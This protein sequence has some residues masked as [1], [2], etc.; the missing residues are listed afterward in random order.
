MIWLFVCF[1]WHLQ[2]VRFDLGGTINLDSFDVELAKKHTGALTNTEL[3]EGKLDHVNGTIRAEWCD[4][5]G[6]V[7]TLHLQKESL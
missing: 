6:N 7:N 3:Y 2:R 4:D 5:R 1:C